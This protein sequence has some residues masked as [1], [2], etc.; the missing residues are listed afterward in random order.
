MLTQNLAFKRLIRRFWFPG[1]L[2]LTCFAAEAWYGIDQDTPHMSLFL[3]EIRHKKITYS[4]HPLHACSVRWS[5]GFYS[6]T[7]A[8][9]LD[10]WVSP[11]GSPAMSFNAFRCSWSPCRSSS[12][13]WRRSQSWKMME[14]TWKYLKKYGTSMELP[15]TAWHFWRKGMKQHHQW[16][17]AINGRLMSFW[18]HHR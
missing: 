1:S 14:I 3:F 6:C 4:K 18:H 9:R 5:H 8:F 13:A 11:L 12:E 15:S 16:P 2:V 7:W 17:P 10:T